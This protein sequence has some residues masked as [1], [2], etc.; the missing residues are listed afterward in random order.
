MHFNQQQRYNNFGKKSTILQNIIDFIP[1]SLLPRVGAQQETYCQ[2]FR[3]I[4]AV[5]CY[6]PVSVPRLAIPRSPSPTCTDPQK[7]DKKSPI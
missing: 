7:L 3:G 4:P 5:R 2:F 6:L 1:T